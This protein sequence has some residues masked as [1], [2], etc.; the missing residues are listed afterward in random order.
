MED[1]NKKLILFAL[2][3]LGLTLISWIFYISVGSKLLLEF[4]ELYIYQIFSTWIL[5]CLI[6][7]IN[8]IWLFVMIKTTFVRNAYIRGVLVW[9]LIAPSAYII[10][11]LLIL[12]AYAGMR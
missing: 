6:F 7:A 11:G 2:E 8:G 10:Y 12:N 1:K 4:I 9:M 3:V 5:I